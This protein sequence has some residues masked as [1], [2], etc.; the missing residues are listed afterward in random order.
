MRTHER[1]CSS[2]GTNRKPR[3]CPAYRDACNACGG[4][5]PLGEVLSEKMAAKLNRHVN[6]AIAALEDVVTAPRAI[7][8]AEKMY[9][10]L[11]PTQGGQ[12]LEE[13]IQSN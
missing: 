8:S 7:I 13:K 12:G 3:Q 4:N 9:S 11:T 6:R 1:K 2:C 10:F 5:R